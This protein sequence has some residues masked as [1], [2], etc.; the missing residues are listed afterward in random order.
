V[1]ESDDFTFSVLQT[2]SVPSEAFAHV[3]R[4]FG[5]NYREANLAY[6]EKSLDKLR[7]IALATSSDGTVAGFALAEARQMDLPRLPG[8]NV[9][10]HGLCCV[11][12][13][14]RRHGLFGRLE[15]AAITANPL[16]PAE[17][18]L[19][20]GRCAHPA[21]FRNFFRNPAAMPHRSHKP[22]DWQKEVGVAVATAYG[23]PAFDPETFVVS[24]SGVPIGW[25]IMEVE[26]TAE[27]WEMFKPVD[28]SKGDSLLGIAWSPGPPKGWLE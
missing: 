24:G 9:N 11:G 27:E 21:S 18:S 14:F 7:Y 12:E 3:M 23:A 26:A 13:R 19:G 2:D 15:R 16:P 6:L 1:V 5:E 22:T 10:L 17:R 20:A 8:A 4:V 25:P 28:R